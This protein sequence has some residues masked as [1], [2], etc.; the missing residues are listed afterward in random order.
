MNIGFDLDRVFIN[1]PPFVP[2]AVIDWLYKSHKN[3]ALAYRIP[4][5]RAEIMIRIFS[6]NAIFR[7]PMPQN[8]AFI[9][10]LARSKSHSL[11]LI[12]SRYDFLETQTLRLL[13]KY[14][15]K[16]A[17]RSINLNTKN[18]QPHLF[19]ERI[20]K[21]RRIHAF[22]DD[23]RELVR[24]LTTSCPHVTVIH[25]DP[26][27]PLEQYFGKSKKPLAPRNPVR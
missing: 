16:N 20:I 1:Y 11:H 12:S 23:D 3:C 5:S 9:N 26:R 13:A 18:E 21:A 7:P 14:K 17:F 19:K 25:Y 22:I 24:Y 15:L 27:V 10:R 4:T 2:D 8:I 6:H